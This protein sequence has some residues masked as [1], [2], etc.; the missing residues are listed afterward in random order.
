[1]HTRDLRSADYNLNDFLLFIVYEQRISRIPIISS[2]RMLI[3]DQLTLLSGIT[4]RSTESHSSRPIVDLL[5]CLTTRSHD[6]RKC[7]IVQLVVID[8]R[9]ASR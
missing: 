4:V 9:M 2:A 3:N 5:R 1:M 7:G 8:L 6:S